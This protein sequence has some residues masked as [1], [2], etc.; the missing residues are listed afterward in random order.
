MCVFHTNTVEL[1][2]LF[3]TPTFSLIT[4]C[5]E[6]IHILTYPY[7]SCFFCQVR[8]LV[9]SLILSVKSQLRFFFWK[10]MTT[11]LLSPRWRVF[12]LCLS[13]HVSPVRNTVHAIEGHRRLS[14]PSLVMRVSSSCFIFESC[15]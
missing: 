14:H 10:D 3:Y 5:W 4:M 6:F 9:N 7:L 1:L 2:Q 12:F 13:Q 15:A 8:T 11:P